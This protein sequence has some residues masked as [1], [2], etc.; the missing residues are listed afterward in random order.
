MKIIVNDVDRAPEFTK[1]DNIVINETDKV[2]ISLNAEDPDGDEITFTAENIPENAYFDGSNLIYQSSFDTVSKPKTW[3]VETLKFLGIDDVFYKQK[4]YNIKLIAQ[5]REESTT[6]K[7]KLTVNNK[8]RAPELLPLD[9]IE[10]NEN[11]KAIINPKVIEYD[12][13]KIK[14]SFSDP[15]KS[16]EW[17]TDYNSAGEY[18]VTVTAFDGKEYATQ[19]LKIKVA[20]SNR[21][22]TIKTKKETVISENQKAFI[23]PVISDPD[24]DTVELSLS[25][26]PKDS[27]I[28]NN[29][30]EW[31]PDYDTTVEGQD[32]D[33]YIT[34]LAKDSSNWETTTD[35]KITVK[36]VNR[37][38]IIYNVSP[39]R[40]VIIQAGVPVYFLPSVID[41]DN[42]TLTYEWK[43]GLKTISNKPAIIRT[44]NNLGKKDITFRVSD[45]KVI[46]KFTW[47]VLVTEKPVVKE[48]I[49]RKVAR[50]ITPTASS[51]PRVVSSSVQGY[52]RPTPKP[53]PATISYTIEDSSKT[54]TAPSA[55]G[56]VN[57][58][59]V[60]EYNTKET[61]NI[62][63]HMQSYQVG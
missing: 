48:T 14:F 5:G 58:F 31:T 27:M 18:N 28:N 45:G 19:N 60:E 44:F 24:G 57:T 51:K 17:Q 33:V 63:S 2:I 6:Q 35:T 42:D 40:Q 37:K 7:L 29:S 41:E 11:E 38:P 50:K 20:N 55:D 54:Q 21:P 39:E 15:I 47:K 36:N 1:I 32:K 56:K 25:K 4:T 34:L 23:T 9:D 16:G 10:I 30:F 61:S 12:N 46:K 13:D 8:N 3:Y 62:P 59:L 22:P 49:A 26:G 43:S 52:T 53:R